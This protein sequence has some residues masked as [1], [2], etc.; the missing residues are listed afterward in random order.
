[1]VHKVPSLFEF[2]LYHLNVESAKYDEWAFIG[3]GVAVFGKGR[4][5]LF[6][7]EYKGVLLVSCSWMK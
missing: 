6:Y 2:D 5:R 4:H 7:L 3:S 1:M